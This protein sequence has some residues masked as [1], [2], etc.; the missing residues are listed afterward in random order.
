MLGVEMLTRKLLAAQHPPSDMEPRMDHFIL[1]NVTRCSYSCV[2]VRVCMCDV[3]AWVF[4]LSFPVKIRFWGRAAVFT[5]ES[6]V[7][8][9]RIV[10][11]LFVFKNKLFLFFIQFEKKPGKEAVLFLRVCCYI[12]KACCTSLY[13]KNTK[14]L[15]LLVK[16]RGV[17]TWPLL[18]LHLRQFH[19]SLW[20]SKN[21][22]T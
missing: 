22:Q 14:C 4:W 12:Y 16:R 18:W 5:L 17:K 9:R 19:F 10:L 7:S 21:K 11:L 3:T 15:R 1:K 2:C 6:S 8:V 20:N 13:L